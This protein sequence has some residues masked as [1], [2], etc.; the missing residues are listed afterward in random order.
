[1]NKINIFILGI[2]FALICSC[3]NDVEML[4]IQEGIPSVI[5]SDIESET[6]I[7]LV[8]DAAD[9]VVHEL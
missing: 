4:Q 6:V 3:E 2:L 9:S 1:M 5:E 7:P 8:R